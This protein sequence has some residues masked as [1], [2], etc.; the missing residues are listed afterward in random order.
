MR[1]AEGAK[2]ESQQSGTQTSILATIVSGSRRIAH[3]RD[4]VVAT[5]HWRI[6]LAFIAI[7][8]SSK[9]ADNFRITRDTDR[10]GK[11]RRLAQQ[12]LKQLEP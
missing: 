11:Y 9:A 12:Q 3:G 6:G 4:L 10:R 8:D 7:G 5:T 1:I 2:S